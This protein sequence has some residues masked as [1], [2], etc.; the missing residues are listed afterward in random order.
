[1]TNLDILGI[2]CLVYFA[3][4]LII[5]GLKPPMIWN[6]GKI[7]GFVSLLGEKGAVALIVGWGLVVGAGGVYLLAFLD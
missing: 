1:M 7:Q 3:L 4:C 5:A 6:I 2:V